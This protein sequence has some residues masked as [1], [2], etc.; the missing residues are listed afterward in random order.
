MID[1]RLL[2]EIG[3]IAGG[4]DTVGSTCQYA[5]AYDD[6]ELFQKIDLMFEIYDV[7][8]KR[9]Y[10]F[11]RSHHH[12]MNDINDMSRDHVFW[13][14]IA[15][16]YFESWEYEHYFR[17]LKPFDKISDKHRMSLDTYLFCR[18]KNLLWQLSLFY[19][20]PITL[21]TKLIHWI[22]LPQ[23]TPDEFEPKPRIHKFG[24]KP[25]FFRFYNYQRSSSEIFDNLG[26]IKTFKELW[27][28]RKLLKEEN[29]TFCEYL[30]AEIWLI[31]YRPY[32][33][34]MASTDYTG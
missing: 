2:D 10:I 16:K 13:L 11:Y 4:G 7:G 19:V 1:P 6:W 17:S 5:I 3:M 22:W 9:Q 23:T 21:V 18:N 26:R 32:T 14:K 29:W 34:Y 15:Q 30:F 33:L 20:L 25:D 27:Q 24:H 28:N 8:E 12:D 31:T